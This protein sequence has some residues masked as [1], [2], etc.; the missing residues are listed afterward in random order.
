MNK[1][2][3]KGTHLTYCIVEFDTK[4]ALYLQNIMESEL[5]TYDEIFFKLKAF[6]KLG[7]KSLEELPIVAKIS[8]FSSKSQ[9]T[10]QFPVG[11][12][13]YS[14]N[15]KKVFVSTVDRLE[16]RYHLGLY[17][18]F[19]YV[20]SAVIYNEFSF[21]KKRDCKYFFLKIEQSGTFSFI[22]KDAFQFNQLLFKHSLNHFKRFYHPQVKLLEI[23]MD[24]S[25]LPF[26][27]GKKSEVVKSIC[28]LK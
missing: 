14:K 15:K 7:F 11:V 16:E 26:S 20:K 25:N 23:Q 6:K 17:K 4:E 24:D 5:I 10:L 27:V 12:L 21:K 3:I 9:Q 19:S 18:E 22:V 13:T 8:G 28:T 2:K 1:L